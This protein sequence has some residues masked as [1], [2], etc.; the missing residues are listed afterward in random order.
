MPTVIRFAVIG[1]GRYTPSTPTLSYAGSYAT[2]NG[3]FRITNYDDTNVYTVT[4]GTVQY[5]SGLGFYTFYV[6]AGTGSGTIKARAAK[7][8][9]DTTTV[10]A[11]RHV[12]DQ[13]TVAFTQCYNPC[14]NCNTSVNP[15]TWSCGCGS[16]CNDAGGGQW[17]ACVCRGPGYSYWNNYGPSGYTWSG[18]NYSSDGSNGEWWRIV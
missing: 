16:G 17:G 6:T 18:G 5:D 15:N 2:N 1:G 9:T 11:Y 13:T 8:V 4:G 14:G 3:K 12:A 7:G 10:T